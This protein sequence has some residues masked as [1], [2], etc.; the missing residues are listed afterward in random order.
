[1]AV[2]G[3]HPVDK[4]LTELC[5]LNKA[6]CVSEW[7]MI[8]TDQIW[9]LR[10]V[11]ASSFLRRLWMKMRVRSLG[12]VKARFV[13]SLSAA[14]YYLL[15]CVAMQSIRC[16]LYLVGVGVCVSVGYNCELCCDSLTDWCHLGYEHLHHQVRIASEGRRVV[17]PPC[18]RSTTRL[19]RSPIRRV[20]SFRSCSSHLFCGRPGGR[21]HVRSGGR[22]SDNVDVELKSHVCR[23]DV[24]K[25]SHMPKYRDALTGWEMRL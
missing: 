12:L 8:S 22:L 5:L 7:Q 23:C 9:L 10:Y 3:R 13:Q 21:R 4:L 19:Q 24:V 17:A 1:V 25:S 20:E 6:Q 2:I 15:G 14:L 16:G 18:P 11:V